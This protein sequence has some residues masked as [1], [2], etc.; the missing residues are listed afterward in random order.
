[1]IAAVLRTA[2]WVGLVDALAGAAF[3]GFLYTPESNV[4]MLVASA[5]LVV[6]AGVLLVLSS[7][8]ASY[9]LVHGRPP[10]AAIGPAARR[11]PVLVLAVVV[12]GALCAAAGWFETWWMA[13]SGEVDAAAIAAGDITKTGWVHGAVRWAVVLVQWVLVPAWTATALAWAAGYETRDVVSLK[14]LT[15]GLHWRLLVVTAIGVALLVWVPWR[16]AYWRPARLPA[17][18]LE[19]VFVGAK[20]VVLYALSQVAWAASLWTAAR[21]VPA[22][23]VPTTDTAPAPPNPT[24]APP[25]EPV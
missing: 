5:L 16:Y 7:G 21:L 17:S 20:L 22:P 13:R 18:S 12:I 15:S 8:S 3:L 2:L 6:V 10:W 9:G 19:V 11:L 14:W 1:M 4:L 25:V 23:A 24:P